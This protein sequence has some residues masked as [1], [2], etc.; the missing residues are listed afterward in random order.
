MI[1]PSAQSY[2]ID[3]NVSIYYTKYHGEQ[4]QMFSEI[5]EEHST[6]STIVHIIID[7][8]EQIY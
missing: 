3:Q 4:S 1:R 6:S 8:I 7:P 2:L 5:Q